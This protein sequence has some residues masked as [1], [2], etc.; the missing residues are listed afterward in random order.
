MLAK[1]LGVAGAIL[2]GVLVNDIWA[3]ATPLAQRIVVVAARS[4]GRDPEQAAILA[5]EWRALIDDRPGQL[6]KLS[7]AAGLLVAGVGRRLGRRLHVRHWRIRPRLALS[8]WLPSFKMR[9]SDAILVALLVGIWSALA[10]L[11]CFV[12]EVDTSWA[13]ISWGIAIAIAGVVTTVSFTGGF[14]VSP[15]APISLVAP[16]P[17]RPDAIAPLSAAGEGYTLVDVAPLVRPFVRSS[18][19][20]RREPGEARRN[21]PGESR[22]VRPYVQGD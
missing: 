17:G 18:P 20:P 19:P 16:V 11:V 4:W 7:T 15:P 1:V 22:L 5:E 14:L 6:F 8:S 10:P 3:L 9:G 2:L 21:E 12:L 13:R